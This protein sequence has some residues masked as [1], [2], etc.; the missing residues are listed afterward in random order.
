LREL[1][2]PIPILGEKSEK[3]ERKDRIE[4]GSYLSANRE[5]SRDFTHK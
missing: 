5:M 4:V 1:P 2:I 3:S